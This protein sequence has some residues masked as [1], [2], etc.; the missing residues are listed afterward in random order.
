MNEGYDRRDFLRTA[1]VAGLGL[2]L[3]ADRLAGAAPTGTGPGAVS[4]PAPAGALRT[5]PPL[6]RVRIGMV[7]VGHQGVGHVR[8]FLA[9]EG[10]EIAAVCDI[11]P[12]KVERVRAMVTEAG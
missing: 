1:A 10:A 7:G 12:E 5:S 4:G 2:G 11:V 3:G 8:N 6:E 9:I